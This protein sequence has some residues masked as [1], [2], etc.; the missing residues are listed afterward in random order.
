MVE[1][2]K[3]LALKA[4]Q[5]DP[6]A[7]REIF[8]RCLNMVFYI[9]KIYTQGD[10]ESAK[11]LTQQVFARAFR[12]IGSLEPPYNI[13]AWCARI[14]HNQGIDHV[15]ENARERRG[16]SEY[17]KVMETHG[18]DP[19]KIMLIHEATRAVA[20][21]FEAGVA[22]ILKETA[23]LYYGEGK[24]V[25]E[26]AVAMGVSKTVVTTRLSR[27]RARLRELVAEKLGDD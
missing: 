17:I 5:G 1:D 3:E 12:S 21:S 10:R 24:S 2:D 8:E 15:K 20:D 27:F 7:C 25:A 6:E 16:L 22:G 23:R 9:S 13:A 4:A 26:T 18:S 14:A 19:E 11:D